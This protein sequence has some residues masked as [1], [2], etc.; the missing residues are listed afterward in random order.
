M[1]KPWVSKHRPKRLKDI[2]H[3]EEAVQ[4]LQRALERGN[5]PHLLFY[6]PAGTGKTSTI[7]AA[8]HQLFGPLKR[9]RVLELNASDERG[10]KVVRNRIKEFAQTI[11]TE[12]A[13]GFPCPPFKI[14]VLDEA[15]AMTIDA[16]AAL[17]RVMEQFSSVTRFCIICNYVSKIIDPITS[18]CAK[19]HFGSLP[20][21]AMLDKLHSIAAVEGVEPS[22]AVMASIIDVSKGDMRSAVQLLQTSCRLFSDIDS[23]LVYEI[24]GVV[25][26]SRIHSV[27]DSLNGDHSEIVQAVTDLCLDGYNGNSILQ[28]IVQAVRDEYGL[29]AN[30]PDVSIMLGDLLWT[31]GVADYRISTGADVY[32]QVLN[33]MI[34]L[35]TRIKRENE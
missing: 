1:S 24:A 25:P 14:I 20:R 5:L 11:S 32:L 18:R 4:F 30:Q 26:M 3:Q 8:A 29:F 23:Q 34:Q 15:D 27:I 33:C 13:K 2:A 9:K 19:F 6:G 22:Q 31:I 10:I 16:Q 28:G 35:H 17:R 21:P 7:M 12:K